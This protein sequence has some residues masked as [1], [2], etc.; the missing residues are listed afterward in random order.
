VIALALILVVV[1]GAANTVLWTV[2]DERVAVLAVARPVAWQQ[3]LTDADVVVVRV[4]RDP[5]VS[6]VSEAQRGQ[7]IGKYAATNLEPGMLLSPGLVADQ[8]LPAPDQQL[9]A[10][11]VRPGGVPARGLRP[12]DAVLVVV[13]GSP[14]TA[15]GG[16]DRA[17][18]G[19]LAPVAARVAQVGAPAADGS[20]TVDVAVSKAVG[21]ALA[22]ALVS[23]GAERRAALV[24]LPLG[25]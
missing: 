10:V 8:G 18:P 17:S 24:L 3:Q 4:S 11:L 5:G 21:A 2:Q 7:V 1:G 6:V 14:A 22:A 23:A 12:G 9:V 20:V 13:A 15:G 25:S 16:G 19:G